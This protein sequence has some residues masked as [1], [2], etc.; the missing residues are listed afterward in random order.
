[1]FYTRR[2]AGKKGKS[3]LMS[4]PRKKRIKMARKF[5]NV[6]AVGSVVH[7]FEPKGCRTLSKGICSSERL[8]GEYPDVLPTEDLLVVK[9]AGSNQALCRRPSGQEVL[10]HINHINAEAD[11]YALRAPKV[12]VATEEELL[13]RRV[14]LELQ[15]KEVEKAETDARD[16]ARALFAADA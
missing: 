8:G 16:E 14:E 13:K 5:A 9:T 10:I 6:F 11:Y 4:S 7:V 3:G 1:M 12:A 15:L 2:V